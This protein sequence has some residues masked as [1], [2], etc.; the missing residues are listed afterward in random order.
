MAKKKRSKLQLQQLAEAKAKYLQ[1]ISFKGAGAASNRIES[2]KAVC[3]SVTFSDDNQDIDM[4]NEEVK[5][6][7]ELST[8]LKLANLT[9]KVKKREKKKNRKRR[10][11]IISAINEKKKV[12]VTH[13]DKKTKRG[14]K[15]NPKE[16]Q[17]LSAAEKSRRRQKLKSIA[18]GAR[19]TASPPKER[20]TVESTLALKVKGSF[21]KRDMATIRKSI[22]TV[23]SNYSTK[24]LEKAVLDSYPKPVKITLADGGEHEIF[25]FDDV[26]VY[27]LRQIGAQNVSPNS[28]VVISGDK[29]DKILKIGFYL[30]E[31]NKPCSEWKFILLA[32]I[33]SDEDYDIC[34]AIFQRVLVSIPRWKAGRIVD[35]IT[36]II[37]FIVTGD[38]KFLNMFLGLQCS[39]CFF[40]CC[41]CLIHKND[42]IKRIYDAPERT[43]KNIID[44][45]NKLQHLQQTSR[46]KKAIEI[47]PQKCHSV[48]A[49]P[50]SV[51][52]EIAEVAPGILHLI[53][54]ATNAV[55]DLAEELDKNSVEK[56]LQDAHLA[57]SGHTQKL[58]GNNGRIILNKLAAGKVVYDGPAFEIIFILSDIQEFAVARIINADEIDEL[59][60]CIEMFAN[61]L[62]QSI[63]DKL[64]RSQYIHYIVAHVPAFV[65]KHHYGTFRSILF[66][67]KMLWQNVS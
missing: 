55:L 52:I 41:K 67:A 66:F 21:T 62:E 8:P 3:E 13:E 24:K 50:M 11:K 2:D 29:G 18:P 59:Q 43:I 51:H 7:C 65:R 27:L 4:T 42:L 15:K 57:R 44:D 56:L 53:A 34:F 9:K 48:K 26:F 58:N 16:W 40:F 45:F 12:V 64:T 32:S 33:E 10:I 36:F 30:C 54:G 20:M 31:R 46:T 39:S 49:M 28:T 1:Q 63:Y 19:V 47:A 37:K 14:P 38:L 6:K 60:V 35:G 17:K 61:Q 22:P 5:L 23:A 25:D